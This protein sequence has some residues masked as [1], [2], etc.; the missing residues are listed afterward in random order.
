MTHRLPVE[1]GSLTAGDREIIGP[2]HRYLFRVLRLEV[3]DR[4]TLFDGRGVEAGA[5]VVRIAARSAVLSVDA[6][7]VRPPP[8]GAR[9][10][11]ALALLKGERMDW[12][13]QKLVELGVDRIIPLRTARTVV[14]LRGQRAEKRRQRYQTIAMAAARQSRRAWIP[15]IHDL[16]DLDELCRLGSDF[17]GRLIL[18]V[19]EGARSLVAALPDPPER[20]CLVV[21]PEGGFEDAEIEH[22]RAAGFITAS[23]GRHI[24]RAETAA[25]AA[26]AVLGFRF[27]DLDVG[28]SSA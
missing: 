21:G 25:L 2:D 19:G 5:T 10:T 9:I 4:L 12:C 18:W 20:I 23:L 8:A 15:A 24:L 7:Q 16:I 17:D 22:A 3:G 6:V 27:G 1:P 13:I 11:V 14:E 28:E 26:T